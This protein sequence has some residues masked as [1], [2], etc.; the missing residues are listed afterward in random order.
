M[1][2]L[3]KHSSLRRGTDPKTPGAGAQHPHNKP[4]GKCGCIRNTGWTTATIRSLRDCM[5]LIHRE[6]SPRLPTAPAEPGNV[7][8]R[9]GRRFYCAV[10]HTLDYPRHLC[11]NGVQPPKDASISQAEGEQ[12]LPHGCWLD[13]RLRERI[14][15]NDRFKSWEINPSPGRGRDYRAEHTAWESQEEAANSKSPLGGCPLPWLTS[16]FYC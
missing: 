15:G 12:A 7:L 11:H 8:G 14:A 3:N 16:F 2:W 4:L 10:V 13:S 5:G 1:P 9:D 6:T